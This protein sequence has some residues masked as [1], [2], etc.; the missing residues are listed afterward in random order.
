[1]YKILTHLGNYTLFEN[2]DIKPLPETKSSPSMYAGCIHN[3]NEFY[4][5]YQDKQ[6]LESMVKSKKTKKTKKTK[7]VKK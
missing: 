5:E 7:K 3:L 1:M 6:K 2:G 4:K